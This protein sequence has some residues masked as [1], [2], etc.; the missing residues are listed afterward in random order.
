[1]NSIR[2]SRGLTAVG[3]F[4]CAISCG[5]SS[6]GDA[7][8]TPS[9]SVAV[10]PKTAPSAVAAP[11]PSDSAKGPEAPKE[12]LNVLLVT[13]DSLRADMPWTG[14]SRPI[15]PN[16]TKL[17]ERS[18]VYP[19]A[20]SA[21]SYTAKSVATLLS[22]RYPSTLYRD[23]YFFAK[24]SSAN[25]FLAEIL[26]E[27]G[28]RT[29]GWHSHLY[30]GRGKGLEQGFA[31]WQLV[32]KITFDP[33]TDNHITSDK[34]TA[35]GMELLGSPSNTGHQF[36]AW[37]HF[38]DPHDQYNKHPES[39]DF[40]RKGRDRYDSEVWYTDMW[41]GKLLSWAE[42][43]P[44]WKNTVLIVSADHGEAFGEHNMY[45]HAFEV[46]EVL[47]RVPLLISG[48]G[49]TPRRI[50]ARRSHIDLPP[51]I[52][53][54]MGVP[55]PADFQG[56]SLLPELRGGTAESRE[57]ILVELTED[58]HNPPRRALIEGDYK[59]IDFGRSHFS[60][61]NLRS[62]PGELTD[63]AKQ[64]PEDLARMRQ[65]L[66]E[67]YKTLPTVEPYGGA[68]LKEGGTARGPLGP[69]K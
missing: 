61:F 21:S 2:P 53:E 12:P 44:F 55:V 23:G 37:A 42:T 66:E 31:E 40:G 25:H 62:D 1:M 48:P 49:I 29:I 30:F 68:K 13:I 46:W 38:M 15:A 4:L 35:L 47:T 11:A 45:K 63:L 3:L 60:L 50:E 22:G 64:Q 24:Y 41:L 8:P 9:Q 18:V 65:K 34:M 19:N 26:S 58:S 67:R 36:F 14:Y 51:T 59:I 7:A 69:S 43:Q 56:K 52:L 16:L 28:V 57:P 54:L 32:P 6:G 33:E 5:K 17:A 27:R 10:S 39:P 20:Y